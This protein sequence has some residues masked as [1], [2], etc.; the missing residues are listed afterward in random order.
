MGR[1]WRQIERLTVPAGDDATFTL[2]GFPLALAG[3]TVWAVS[4]SR[5]LTDMTF[6]PQI[7]GVT[8]GASTN[9]AAAVAAEVVYGG[10]LDTDV[11]PET[12]PATVDPFIFTV[13][14]SNA[15]G[16]D[17]DVTIVAVGFTGDH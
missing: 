16:S 12:G 15:G 17:E 14:L 2:K 6:Q 9:I 4:G 11:V 10:G 13:L 5:T 3:L 8:Y 1:S 7:N